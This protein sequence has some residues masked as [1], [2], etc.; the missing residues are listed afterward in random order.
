L[1]SG[2]WHGA[3]ITFIIWGAI[4]GVIIVLEKAFSNIGFTIRRN[5]LLGQLFFMPFTFVL[6]TFAWIFF[7]AN[8]FSDSIYI[9]QNLFN[10]KGKT[11]YFGL[12]L[13]SH[14]FYL[15]IIAIL[16]L[17]VFDALHRKYN[18]IKILDRF[19][20]V[21]RQLFYVIIIFCILIF[22]VYGEEGVSEFIYFQF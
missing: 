21:L 18:A 10:W 13:P 14:E 4:H 3:A 1:V 5:T 20:F 19:H 17:L 6:A 7:R 12:G 9:S 8:S 22:G 16:L 15:A 2:L 11:Q